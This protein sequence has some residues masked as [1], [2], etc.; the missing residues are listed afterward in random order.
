[1]LTNELAEKLLHYGSTHWVGLRAVHAP[2]MRVRNNP[3]AGRVLKLSRVSGLI[4]FRY[5]KSVN[6]QRKREAQPDDFQAVP[7]SWGVRIVGSP[8][9]L[10]FDSGPQFYLEVKRERVER[11]YFDANTLEPINEADLIPYLPRRRKSKRQNLDSEIVLRDYRLDHIAELSIGGETLAVDPSWW[12]LQALRSNF[13]K[14][15]P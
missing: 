9:V 13:R 10:H 3:F 1:M 14:G 4:N 15:T 6:A 12:K 5:T 2:E 11:W 7:R 8:L